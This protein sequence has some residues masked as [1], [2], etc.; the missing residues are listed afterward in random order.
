MRIPVA[1]LAIFVGFILISRAA[2][3]C[4]NW[5]EVPAESCADCFSA[6][7]IPIETIECPQ[8]YQNCTIPAKTY[9]IEALRQIDITNPLQRNISL[10]ASDATSIYVFAQETPRIQYLSLNGTVSTVDMQK[11][12][13]NMT[14]GTFTILRFTPFMNAASGKPSGCQNTSIDGLVLKVLAPSYKNFPGDRIA[15]TWDFETHNMSNGTGQVTQK[16]G[17]SQAM[18]IGPDCIY[19]FGFGLGLSLMLFSLL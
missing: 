18:R 7:S 14:P 12:D 11:E 17:K 16:N 15:G 2:A 13:R 3:T 19:K 8:D 4:T 10:P 1:F 5:T 9:E 6:Y